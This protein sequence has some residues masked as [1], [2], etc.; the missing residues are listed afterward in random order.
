MVPRRK[1]RR[2]RRLNYREGSWFQVP[3][4]PGSPVAVGL[5]AR[6]DLPED[7]LSGAGAVEI[8]LQKLAGSTRPV[9]VHRLAA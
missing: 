7:G 2:S 6:I 9:P 5:A 3:L 4:A 1:T 8:A